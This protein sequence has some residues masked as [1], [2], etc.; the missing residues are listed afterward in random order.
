MGEREHHPWTI[1]EELF[2]LEP[3]VTGLDVEKEK[4]MNCKSDYF[5]T[6]AVEMNKQFGNNSLGWVPL[7]SQRIRSKFRHFGERYQSHAKQGSPNL[8]QV[9]AP[10]LL[11][12][13]FF[14]GYTVFFVLNLGISF[15]K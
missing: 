3:F 15:I 11:V 12:H 8:N 9:F 13:C 10:L 6:V 4:F 5:K 2:V 14:C 1:A 7:T